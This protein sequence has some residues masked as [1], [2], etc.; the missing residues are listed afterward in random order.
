LGGL[1]AG[2]SYISVKKDEAER[3]DYKMREKNRELDKKKDDYENKT[4]FKVTGTVKYT[5]NGVTKSKNV[6]KVY[7]GKD[8]N[9]ERNYYKYLNEIRSFDEDTSAKAFDYFLLSAVIVVALVGIIIKHHSFSNWVM[10]VLA[11]IVLINICL[12]ISYVSGAK[13]LEAYRS[14]HG[15]FQEVTVQR[16]AAAEDLRKFSI[17]VEDERKEVNAKFSDEK[18]LICQYAR[19]AYYALQNSYKDILDERDWKYVDV[20]IYYF[21]T[22]RATTMK[23]A[24]QLLD[25]QLQTDQIV[26]TMQQSAIAI[27]ES[28]NQ[29][30]NV[31]VT[32]ATTII[33]N[34]EII[35]GQQQEMIGELSLQTALLSKINTSSNSLAYDVNYMKNHS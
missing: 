25:R 29:F 26:N 30:K 1:R 8:V 11:A 20:L 35:I 13:K 4:S 32:Y 18:D 24:L 3:T 22:G 33:E 10:Y 14:K 2:M 6:E 9:I 27:T 17:G 15:Y 19:K 21:Q 31:F 12:I 7:K 23:E 34:Q 28:I 5:E 16:L